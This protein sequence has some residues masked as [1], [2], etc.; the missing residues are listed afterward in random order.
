MSFVPFVFVDGWNIVSY[1]GEQLIIS[2]MDI[3]NY[4]DN[5]L[6]ESEIKSMAYSYLTSIPLSDLNKINFQSYEF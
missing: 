3:K 4:K 1:L 5:G 6:T 2:E